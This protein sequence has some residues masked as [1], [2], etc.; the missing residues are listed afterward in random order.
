MLPLLLLQLAGATALF[1]VPTLST[2]DLD[3]LRAVG[4]ARDLDDLQQ[5]MTRAQETTT[6]TM[7]RGEW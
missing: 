6:P 1:T 4:S 2:R 5:G 7:K 3:D